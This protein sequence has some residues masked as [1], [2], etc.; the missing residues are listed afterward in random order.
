MA[1]GEKVADIAILCQVSPHTVRSQIK[2]IFLKAEVSSQAQLTALVRA[3]PVLRYQPAPQ[4]PFLS[5]AS[6]D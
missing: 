5:A 4:T 2:S 1:Q 3:L 6:G